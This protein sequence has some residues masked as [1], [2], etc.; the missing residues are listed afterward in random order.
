MEP[1]EKDLLQ[2]NLQLAEDNNRM[3]HSMRRSQRWGAVLRIVWWLVIFG[4][5]AAAYYY[6]LQ[7][8]LEQLLALYQKAQQ[9]GAQAESAMEQFQQ[10]M[11]NFAN[12]FP[13]STTTPQ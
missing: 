12:F 5:S 8:Y 1:A 9:G 2:R 6:Y 13:H 7:P 11:A 3:L 10:M 4:A